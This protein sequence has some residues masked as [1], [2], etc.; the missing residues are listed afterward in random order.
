MS[1]IIIAK[2]AGFCY[3]VKRAIDLAQSVPG[4]A[5]SL[6][7]LI[8]NPQMISRLKKEG[9]DCVDS[10]DQVP[11]S[12]TV[13]IRAHGETDA[14]FSKAK[15][16]NLKVVNATCPFVNKVHVLAKTME[17][18]GYQVVVLGEADHPEIIGIIGNL[19]AGMVINDLA[20]AKKLPQFKKIGLV[21]QTT[22][23]HKTFNN[24]KKELSSHCQELKA[25]DTIC[26]ATSSRQHAARELAQHVDYLIVIGGKNS[27]NTNRLFQICNELT[28]SIH[29]ETVE[30]LDFDLIK[31]KTT[32]G[33]TAGASTPDFLIQ[34]VVDQISKLD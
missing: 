29:I 14:V 6:G 8:H 23:Q 4:K 9:I 20:Q 13:I 19:R 34:Q 2:K 12:A 18:D 27:G 24:I 17:Q 11:D 26:D 25:I 31:K 16:K 32:V 28:E 10:I 5:F 22:Q 1:K 15:A 3:G 30:E 7:Q 21:S 33:I